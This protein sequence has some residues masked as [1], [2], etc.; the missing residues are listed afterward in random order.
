MSM[1]E[2]LEIGQAL[3]GYS[4][5]HRQLA[6]SVSLTSKDVYELSMRSDLAPGASLSGTKSYITGFQL[7]DTRSYALIKT[8]AAPEM[9]R[10][11]CVWSHVLILSRSFLSKQA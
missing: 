4:E 5:G 11:G 7:P 1:P 6:S 2:E 3:F 10:P 9:P 8:W